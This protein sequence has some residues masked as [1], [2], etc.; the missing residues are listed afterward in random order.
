[1]LH[2]ILCFAEDSKSP[3]AD[4]LFSQDVA[5]A[6]VYLMNTT[7]AL[8]KF[9]QDS[10][11]QELVKTQFVRNQITYQTLVLYENGLVV[12]MVVSDCVDAYEQKCLLASQQILLLV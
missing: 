10:A 9:A 12:L 1:M 2:R 8:I 4:V 5:T 6:P 7:K 3:L 11:R